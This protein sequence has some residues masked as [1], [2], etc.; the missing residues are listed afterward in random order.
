MKSS[1]DAMQ[2]SKLIRARIRNY[3]GARQA[4]GKPVSTREKN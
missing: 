4:E 2:L 1:Q 3:G